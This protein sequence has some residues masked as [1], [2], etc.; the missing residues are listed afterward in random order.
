MY[1]KINRISKID[2]L[3]I[4]ELYNYCEQYGSAGDTLSGHESVN[5]PIKV[6]NYDGNDLYY[7]NVKR[8]IRHKV[9]KK[10]WRIMTNSGKSVTVTNDH[11]MIVYRND[12]QVVCKPEEMKK[13][14]K[15]LCKDLFGFGFEKISYVGCIGEFENEFVYDIEIDDATHTFM[16]ND[17]LV[18]NSVY[19]QLD[20]VISTTDWCLGDKQNWKIDVEYKDGTKVT[21]MFCGNRTED[22]VI[23]TLNLESTDVENYDMVKVK[24]EAKDF[25]IA[26]DDAFLSSYFKKIFDDYAKKINADNYLNFEL[27]TYAD[28]GIW[29]AKK[30]YIQNIRWTDSMARHDIL[31]NFSKIKAKGVEL[32]QPSSPSFARTKLT[33]LVRWIFSHPNFVLKDFVEELRK[34][35]NEFMVANPDEI[36][37]NKKATEYMK[38]VIDDNKE[39]IMKKNTPITTK[40]IAY[41]NYKLNNNPKYKSRYSNLIP[42][43]KCKYYYCVDQLCKMFAYEPGMFPIEFAPEIN[44]KLMFEKTILAPINR[45]VEAIGFAPIEPDLIVLKNAKLF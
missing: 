6:L 2:S 23:D 38:W 44:R 27:E 22:E 28:S 45:I 25:A 19:S 43:T 17:I 41:Y 13:T 39:L 31:D 26:L 24:G 8:V 37:W 12:K 30:K 16:A 3:T 29:L 21:C 36:S 35:K 20:E 42:G 14:D 34:I 9:S 15:L 32:I 10:K 40:G 18:H 7:A 4:E 33:Y 5:C 11:S 1:Q